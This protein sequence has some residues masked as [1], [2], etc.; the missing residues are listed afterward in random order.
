[1]N[2]GL[3][4]VTGQLGCG[5]SSM[6]K[7]IL[8]EY[9]V[10]SGE[11]RT[12]GRKSYASQDPWLFPSS[13]RQNILFGEKYDEERYRQVIK[14]CALEYD[15]KILD[16]GDETI[17]ADRGL[18][19]SKGQQARVNLARAVY[20]DS[21]IYLIDDALT[22]LDP[23]V[24]EQIFSECIL[25]FLKGKLIVLVTHNSK[26]ITN[27][28]K[29]IVL[30]DGAITF[31]GK[32]QELTRDI[33]E[34]IEDEEIHGDDE[35]NA[36]DYSEEDTEKTKL[37]T[38]PPK[39]VH[40]Y[41]E[42]KKQ[43]GVGWDIYKQYFRFGGGIFFV[44]FIV[45]LYFVSTFAESASSKMLTNWMGITVSIP[46]FL[47]NSRE[48]IDRLE[49]ESAKSLNLYT[50]LLVSGT[51][52]EL[53]KYYLIFKFALNASYN[54]HKAMIKSIINAVMSFFDNY[55]IG[56]ILNRFS[57]DLAV[58]DEHFPFVLSHFISVSVHSFSFVLEI[59]VHLFI[60]MA[61]MQ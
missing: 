8:K 60:R 24:Q 36:N 32:H 51:L 5:K 22:A 46:T 30:K 3:N 52:C 21:D 42:V 31:D 10:S 14:V 41:H 39:R 19:L 53:V 40:V 15:F 11:L 38:I 45:L 17:V 37:L 34:A 23:K 13:I 49:I 61:Y 18:N 35:N 2:V 25:G 43:G 57:Q 58:I 47:N 26:H 44:S 56:N 59:F 28:D 27:A 54:L 48:K 50:I 4:V 9:P 7:T 12:R 16:K 6:I 20:K 55:F 1:M 33:L 29:V